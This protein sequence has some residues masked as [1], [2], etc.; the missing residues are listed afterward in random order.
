MARHRRGRRSW[1]LATVPVYL[2][3]GSEF[4]PPLDEGSLLYMPTTMPGISITEAQKVLQVTDR[5]IKQ[6]PEVDRVLGKAG[7]AETSTDPA[8]LSMLETVIILK[9]K[10]EWRK[11]RHLVF[12]LG[13]GLGPLHLPALHPR[14]H[15]PGRAHQPDE[16]GPEPAGPGQ[17]LDD[18]H[19]GPDRHAE[20][21]PADARGAQDLGLATWTPSRRSGPRSK[22]A[23]N[24]VEG[25]RSVFAER[26]G[27]GYFLDIE[28]NREALARY[29]LSIEEAQE[30][31]QRAIG[32]ENITTTVEGRERYPVNVRYMRDFRADIGALD[33]VLVPVGGGDGR[34]RCP[35]WPTVKVA[36][37]RP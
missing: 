22:P 1:S 16:R 17:R 20:H 12:L 6:F 32:G 35:S 26:T 34:S 13:A 14:P 18:A 9:P 27:S 24:G 4:M 15:L 25:T 30:V 31:I 5:I 7:R 37:G 23:L 8:P 3:L 2:K 33:R 21:G 19:Q 11:V 28:W 36:P 29:G 10:S